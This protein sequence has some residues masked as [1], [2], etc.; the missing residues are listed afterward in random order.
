MTQPRTPS[1]L[2]RFNLYVGKRQHEKLLKL[3]EREGVPSA[4]LVRRAIDKFL[5]RYEQTGRVAA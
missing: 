1:G 3:Y 2:V 5:E 4:E